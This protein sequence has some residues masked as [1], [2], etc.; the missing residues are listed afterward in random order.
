MV[1]K[2]KKYIVTVIPIYQ[3]DI[4][5]NGIIVSIADGNGLLPFP[6]ARLLW[7]EYLSELS[8]QIKLYSIKKVKADQWT[9]FESMHSELIKQLYNTVSAKYVVKMLRQVKLFIN[10][11]VTKVNLDNPS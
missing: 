8:I 11:T 1:Q 7:A 3:P 4:D 10:N 6:K 9:E 5:I 2:A